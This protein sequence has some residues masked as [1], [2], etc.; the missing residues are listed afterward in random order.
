MIKFINDLVHDRTSLVS[1][2]PT[3]PLDPSKNSTTVILSNETLDKGT[4]K[5][6]GTYLGDVFRL[7]P[8]GIINK[9]ET[10]IGAT[11]LELYALRNS[12]IVEP[13][14]ITA[15]SKAFRQTDKGKKC[16][17]VGSE[18][19]YHPLRS[20]KKDILA[21]IKDSSILHKKFI[22]VADSLP[23]LMNVLEEVTRLDF[24]F[25]LDEIDSFQED[26]TFRTSMEHCMDYYKK[27]NPLKR[28]LTTA[29]LLHFSD[30]SLKDEPETIFEYE[31][32]SNNTIH[33]FPTDNIQE[34]SFALIKYLLEK[35]TGKIVVAH[36]S[37]D[38]NVKIANS[39]VSNSICKATDIG[40]LCSNKK[41]N[42]DKCDLYYAEL[43][44]SKLP[45]RLCLMTSAY[46]SGFDID[47]QFHAISLS[48]GN[49]SILMLSA[50]SHKQIVGRCRNKSG[51]L[52]NSFV[53]KKKEN[54]LDQVFTLEEL[55]AAGE[56]QL[57]ALECMTSRYEGDPFL[58]AMLKEIRDNLWKG[59][60]NAFTK[61]VRTMQNGEFAVSFFN[62][63]A[64]FEEQNSFLM[65]S[66]DKT[67][68]N[69]FEKQGNIVVKPKF[70]KSGKKEKHKKMSLAEYKDAIAT[71]VDDI[72]SFRFP[73]RSDVYSE[74][75]RPEFVKQIIRLYMFN[76]SKITMTSFTNALEKRVT[77]KLSFNRFKNA[78]KFFML[79]ED[80]P[81]FK[82]ILSI[83]FPAD[84]NI[85]LKNESIKEKWIDFMKETF[86]YYSE[87]HDIMDD[88]RLTVKRMETVMQ[89]INTYID[90]S[91][92][93]P[94]KDGTGE[95]N[96]KYVKSHN[97]YNLQ[98]KSNMFSYE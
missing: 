83:H 20:R 18:T 40:I 22:V 14:K 4:G 43:S 13:L 77:D 54:E 65:H 9:T 12:I 75:D 11:T 57:V 35:S 81:S 48:D 51:V 53:Y 78:L 46:F 84:K 97:P 67:V 47:E 5:L 21:Y 29:T 98:V 64:Y 39:L 79:L 17:Y 89:E 68:I 2:E 94:C 33:L 26:S 44:D 6:R 19:T 7:L 70:I 45:K 88:E 72:R 49:N 55:L 86:H 42:K 50:N 91:T 93:Q 10:G 66:S 62:I 90:I 27:W 15:S 37:V 16:L 41:E 60:G 8:H 59:V 28:A 85:R 82:A 38:G 32:S 92:G 23:G 52:S 71:A 74:W 95:R 76:S 58:V 3:Y 36:N 73:S 1:I 96:C 56:K 80:K 31:K 69:A 63:D 87:I 34:A 25:L 30:P 24:F 61:F